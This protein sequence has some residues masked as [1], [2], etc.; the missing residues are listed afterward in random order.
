MMVIMLKY[1]D[2]Y[3]VET[4]KQMYERAASRTLVKRVAI[5][6]DVGLSIPGEILA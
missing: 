3:S 6:E 1:I 4:R 5:P 2:C